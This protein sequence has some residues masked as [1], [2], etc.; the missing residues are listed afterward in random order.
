MSQVTAKVQTKNDDAP[1]SLW[2]LPPLSIWENF[3]SGNQMQ[4]WI[5]WVSKD[6]GS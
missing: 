1:G 4:E 5:G 3:F 6:M 2:E